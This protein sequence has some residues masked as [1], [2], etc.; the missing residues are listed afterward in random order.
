MRIPLFAVSLTAL[1]LAGGCNRA[2][3]EQRKA[4]EARAEANEDVSE[5][6]REAQLKINAARGEANS[7]IAEA[8]ANFNK[9]RE[10]YRHDMNEKLAELDREIAEL[11][12]KVTTAAGQTKT[13]LEAKLPEVKRHRE[14]FL[15]DYRSLEQTSARTWDD[16]KERVNKSWEQLKK[17]VDDAD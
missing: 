7:E 16:A 6:Q 15:A 12:T 14:A 17:A 9:L 1:A 8:A 3:D 11:D 2:A 13:D 4:D 5:A 10:D